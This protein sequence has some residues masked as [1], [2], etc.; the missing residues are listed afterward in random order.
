LLRAAALGRPSSSVVAVGA[1]DWPTLLA[2]PRAHS[3]MF[4]GMVMKNADVGVVV[5]VVA[6]SAPVAV[7]RDKSPAADV[8][9]VR[10]VL[11]ELVAAVL[12]QAVPDDMPL[13]QARRKRGG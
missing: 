4:L 7:A 6:A 11:A 1:F 10:A 12:G 5:G 13:M 3:G 8:A 9:S 2:G